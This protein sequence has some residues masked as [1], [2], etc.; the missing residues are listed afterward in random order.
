MK[1]SKHTPGPWTAEIT[2]NPSQTFL[3][4]GNLSHRSHMATEEIVA[5]VYQAEST[6]ANATLIAAAPELLN[7]LVEIGLTLQHGNSIIPSRDPVVLAKIKA[8]LT[9]ATGSAE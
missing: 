5:K 7:F 1:H 2:D 9:K 8:L 4:R 3:I 6:E